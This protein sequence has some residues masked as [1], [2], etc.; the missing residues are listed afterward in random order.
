MNQIA[1]HA[2]TYGLYPE[3]FDGLKEDYEKLWGLLSGVLK[4]RA[5]LVGK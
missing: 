3:E 1:V 4:E 2:H 5:A